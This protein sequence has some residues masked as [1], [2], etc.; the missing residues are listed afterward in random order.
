MPGFDYMT[1][2]ELSVLAGF[3]D[4]ERV[5]VLC[6]RGRFPGAFRAGR[7]WLIPREAALRW[8]QEDRDRRTKEARAKL[9]KAQA[10]KEGTD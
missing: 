3:K 2:S 10:K 6:A 4:T 9:G 7:D 1:T 8:L 5:R